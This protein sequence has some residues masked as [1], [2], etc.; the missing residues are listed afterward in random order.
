MIKRLRFSA[1]NVGLS[2]VAV[3]L[4]VLTLFATPL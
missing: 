1:L 3:S 2:Y 4:V